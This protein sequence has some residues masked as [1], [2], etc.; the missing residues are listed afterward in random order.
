MKTSIYIFCVIFNLA[1]Y[2][3]GKNVYMYIWRT[4]T[5]L[6]C[7]SAT[8]DA[9]KIYKLWEEK[10]MNFHQ[11]ATSVMRAFKCAIMMRCGVVHKGFF[12]LLAIEKSIYWFYFVQVSKRYSV[13]KMIERV[14]PDRCEIKKILAAKGFS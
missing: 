2:L 6:S 14:H 3:N 10:K 7:I 9:K 4:N 1:H 8:H 11:N 13:P 12:F 5:I